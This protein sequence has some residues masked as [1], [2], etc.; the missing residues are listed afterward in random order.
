MNWSRIKSVMILVLLAANIFLVYTIISRYFN[1]NYVNEESLVT[2][3]SVLADSGVD[4]DLGIIDRKRPSMFIYEAVKDDDYQTNTAINLSGSTVSG[5]F[6][7]PTG[8][9][10]TMENG[11]KLEFRNGFGFSYTE[12]LDETGYYSN[13]FTSFLRNSDYGIEIKNTSDFEKIILD[14]LTHSQSPEDTTEKGKIGVTD[15]KAYFNDEKK[16]YIVTAVQT[17]DGVRIV[18]AGQTDR[19]QTAVENTVMCIINQGKNEVSAAMG[20]WCFIGTSAREPSQLY[21]QMNILFNEKKRAEANASKIDYGEIDEEIMRQQLS[22]G[23]SENAESAEDNLNEIIPVNEFLFPYAEPEPERGDISDTENADDPNSEDTIFSEN[24]F[25]LENSVETDAENKGEEDSEDSNGRVVI[26]SLTL[27]YC[28]YQLPS[29]NH[30]FFIPGWEIIRDDGSLTI[31]NGMNGA[32][33]T[34][35][36]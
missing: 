8:V 7:S 32:I 17:M 36:E 6:Q 5:K 33:Y 18:S 23:S 16:C 35:V 22:S 26:T 4:F 31:Y 11:K 3:K 25:S 1:I 28:L 21:D 12:D 9:V 29:G 10:I 34:N 15:V 14:F 24:D 19:G 13:I 20:T 30:I 27:C 2:L